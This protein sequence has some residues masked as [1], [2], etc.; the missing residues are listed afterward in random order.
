[1]IP[2]KEVFDSYWRFA[3][4]RQDVFFNR[5]IGKPKPWSDDLILNEYKFCNVYRASDRVSQFLIRNVIYPQDKEEYS[6]EDVVFRILLFKIF[7]KVETWQ[8]FE[9]EFKKITL[10]NFDFEKFASS[11]DKMQLSEPIYTPAYMSCANKAFGFDKKHYNHLALIKKMCVEDNISQD[12][13]SAKSFEQVYSKIKSYPLMGNFMAY[14]LATDLNY[15]E[16]VDFSENDFTTIGPGSIRGIKKC[17]IDLE[18]E[19]EVDVIKWMQKNQR[20]EFKK[21]GLNF[22]DLFGREMQLIDCQG[23]FC[24]T[25][26]YS[27]VAFP[28]LKSERKR[29]KAKFSAGV[30][31]IEYFFPPKW[32]IND[33][34]QKFI[35]ENT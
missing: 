21:L 10:K 19:D 33:R 2:R 25:D 15:S 35:A 18:G 12:I 13:L 5:L 6:S 27:R 4:K 30:N 1:M 16:V 8:H 28:G 23:L 29:I 24:E 14:Q 7:N 17:F 34:M 32:K 22:K 3:A 11:L 26:K 20:K 31:R 9:K